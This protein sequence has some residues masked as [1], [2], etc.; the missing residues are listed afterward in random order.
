MFKIFSK[1]EKKHPI[2]GYSYAVTTGTYVGEML[3]YV[4]E[5][6]ENYKFISIPKNI[7]REVPKDKFNLGLDNSIV[8]IVE[9]IPKSIYELLEKQYFYNENHK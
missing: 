6:T 8:E 1:E 3:V 2:R 4:E 5:Q 9:E 7:N